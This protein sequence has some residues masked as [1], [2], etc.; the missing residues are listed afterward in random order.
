[1]CGSYF[2]LKGLVL[3]LLFPWSTTQSMSSKSW[4]YLPL[5]EIMGKFLRSILL[6]M[7]GKIRAEIKGKKRLTPEVRQVSRFFEFLK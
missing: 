1:M 2:G 4:G 5:C 7:C 6:N 3:I